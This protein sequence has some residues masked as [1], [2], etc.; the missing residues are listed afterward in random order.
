MSSEKCFNC[1]AEA[2]WRDS[3]TGAHRCRS[4]VM[5]HG[6]G[7]G[8]VVL[9][10][11]LA[12]IDSDGTVVAEDNRP[13]GEIEAENDAAI[14]DEMR[15]LDRVPGGFDPFHVWDEIALSLQITGDEGEALACAMEAGRQA[16]KQIAALRRYIAR[17]PPVPFE[18]VPMVWLPTVMDDQ[19][20]G[21]AEA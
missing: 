16:A 9:P 2:R 7:R 5:T 6:S 1:G 20:L 18:V 15:E 11:D 19:A 4:C 21:R 8:H 10:R 3:H 13:A 17:M 14:L 12:E